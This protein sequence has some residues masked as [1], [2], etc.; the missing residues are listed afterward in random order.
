MASTTSE[1]IVKI[2]ANADQFASELE[3]VGSTTKNLEKNLATV[4]KISG[5]AFAAGTATIAAA[6]IAAGNF[7]DKFTNVVTL[8]DKGSFASKSLEQGIEGLKKGVIE[9]G[10]ETGASFEDLNKA[11]FD[12]ISSGVPAEEAIDT[13]RVTTQLAAAGATD[14]ATAVQALTATMTSFGESAGTAAEISEKFFTAQKFG[15]TTVGDLASEFS[16]V[17]GTANSLGISFDEALASLSALTADGAKPTNVAA[18]QLKATLTSLI[19][20]QKNL[21][22]ESQAIQE[23]LSLQNL[24][25]KG[26]VGVLDE[27]KVATGGNVVEMQRLFGSAEGL[28]V[29]LSLTGAQSELVKK[30]IAEMADEQKR[31]AVF[32][33]A[34]A[35]K[36]EN[37]KKAFERFSRVIETAAIVLG[38]QFAPIVAK[39]AELLGEFFKILVN[40]PVLAKTAALVIGLG[41]ALAG[42]AAAGAL[43]ATAFLKIRAAMV[44]LSI[45]TKVLSIGIKGLVGAT[46]FGLL[47]IVI[48]EIYANW[49]TIWPAVVRIFSATVNALANLGAGLGKILKG[50]FTFDGDAIS[51]GMDMAKKA[52]SDGL[53]DI[54]DAVKGKEDAKVVVPITAKVDESQ[55]QGEVDKLSKAGEKGSVSVGAGATVAKGDSGQAAKD[56]SLAKLKENESA[57][58]KALNEEQKKRIA[59]NK[60][61]LDLI[62]NQNAGATQQELDFIKRKNELALAEQAAAQEKNQAVRDSELELIAAQR[63]VLLEEERVF[64]EEKRAIQAEDRETKAALN[65]ELKALS[66]SERAELNQQELDQIQA[67]ILSKR[68]VEDSEAKRK[69]DFEIKR[70]NQYL[71]DEKQFGKTSAEINKFL[72]SESVQLAK[73]SANELVGL[74]QSKNKTLASIGKAASVTQIAIDTA[75]N[76]ASIFAKLNALFPILAPGIGFAGAAAITAFGAEKTANVLAA[77]EGGLVPR[78]LGTPGKD[79]IPASLTPGELV[80]PEKNF[81]EVVNSVASQRSGGSSSSDSNSALVGLLSSIDQK[82]N[83]LES[84]VTINGDVL[85]SEPF[86]DNIMEK[87]RDARDFRNAT[88][89]GL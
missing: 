76:A 16:K 66:E 63:A 24:K 84:P 85:D 12:L 48:S 67:Q 64:L 4:A 44:A 19:N 28:A 32:A 41:T 65:E 25:S 15:V 54:I 49:E 7:E 50:I 8:L 75:T 73:Q 62:Q 14:T 18:T 82:L 74:A 59:Q 86:V 10:Q 80:V 29:A 81:D 35:V 2:G 6:T 55:V 83:K 71:K 69:L 9:L 46:G 5:A 88:L 53:D 30:Q 78:N 34:L 37:S 68:E 52:I 39:A 51:E 47:L 31:A 60:A 11:L 38:E 27:L 13:L 21:S 43:A 22:S 45:S 42:I 20:V 17:A 23:A 57:K 58:T 72:S 70:R 40:N 26:L 1:L 87:I 77:N 36:Q 79:S 3:K 56:D 61:A 89:E 33:D